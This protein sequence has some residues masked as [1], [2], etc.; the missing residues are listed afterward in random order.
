M[1][2]SGKIVDNAFIYESTYFIYYLRVCLKAGIRVDAKLSPP[3]R[4]SLTPALAF[5]LS[6]FN[7]VFTSSFSVIV[8]LLL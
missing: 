1:S 6:V 7:F 5:P 8:P 3:T 2:G 4:L